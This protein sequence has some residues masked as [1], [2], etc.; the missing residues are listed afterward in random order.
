MTYAHIQVFSASTSG[1]CVCDVEPSHTASD[2]ATLESSMT[3]NTMS[4]WESLV[5]F[6]NIDG[7]C[8]KMFAYIGL[9]FHYI[10]II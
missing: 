8:L 9:P 3:S 5:S 6:C 2:K 1:V 4:M 7:V 10:R